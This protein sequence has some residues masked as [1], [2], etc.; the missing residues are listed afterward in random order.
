M[1]KPIFSGIKE[2]R[3]QG[4]LVHYEPEQRGVFRMG[5]DLEIVTE[6]NYTTVHTDNLVLDISKIIIPELK[7]TTCFPTVLTID[8]RGKLTYTYNWWMICSIISVFGIWYK[9]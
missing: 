6:K 8:Y 7:N 2:D 9:S 4:V 1:S 3:L 5:T